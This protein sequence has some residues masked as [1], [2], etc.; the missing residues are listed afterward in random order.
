MALKLPELEFQLF[1]ASVTLATLLSL[2]CK[3]DVVSL[4]FNE[5]TLYKYLLNC[6][7]HGKCIKMVAALLSPFTFMST[8]HQQGQ[9][10]THFSPQPLSHTQHKVEPTGLWK[11]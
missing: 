11:C 4:A 10:L 6:L 5:I 9:G 2:I 7:A 8:A 3:M 1:T